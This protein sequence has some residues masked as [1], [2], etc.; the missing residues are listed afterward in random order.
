MEKQ[1]EQQTQS[2]EQD[3][4]LEILQEAAPEVVAPI[5]E[6]PEKIASQAAA[7]MSAV[8]IQ[9]LKSLGEALQLLSSAVGEVKT[10]SAE[11][12]AGMLEVGQMKEE[13]AFA[14]TDTEKLEAELTE[15][16]ELLKTEQIKPSEVA[17]PGTPQPTPKKKTKL[18]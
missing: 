15:K 6:T 1:P 8:K 14:I 18:F 4:P 2:Q 7:G 13:L 11:L 17:K 10:L 5:V 12:R 3:K 9:E 16:M